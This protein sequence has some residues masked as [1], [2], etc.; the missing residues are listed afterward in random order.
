MN[1]SPSHLWTIIRGGAACD[2][3]PGSQRAHAGL[4]V[5][6]VLLWEGF[7]WVSHSFDIYANYTASEI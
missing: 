5:K 4:R 7:G 3:K 6:N 2:A 1:F